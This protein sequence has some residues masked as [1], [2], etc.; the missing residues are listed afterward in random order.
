M[1]EKQEKL[2]PAQ[3]RATGSAK[4]GRRTALRI[5]AAAG[6]AA[7]MGPWIVRD[8]FSSSG[9]LNIMMWS[10]YLPRAVLQRF[11]KTTGIKVRHTPYGSND[12][13]FNKLKASKGRNFDLVSPTVSRAGQWKELALLQP[14]DMKKVDLKKIDSKILATVTAAGSWDGNAYLVPF[15][16]GT[17]GM[18]WNT[19]KWARTPADLSFGDLWLPEMKGQAM[20]RPASMM[21]GLGLYL[22][23]IGRLPSNR[24]LD[25]YKDEASMRDIWREIGKFAIKRKSWFKSYWSDAQGQISGF[26][27]NGVV[28]GQVWDGPAMR[29]KGEGFP[30]TY[31]APIEGAIGWIDGLSMPV[32]AEN[33]AQAYEF[34]KFIFTP[35]HGAAFSNATGYDT[36]GVGTEKHLSKPMREKH[37]TIYPGDAFEKIWWR[38]AEPIW[39]SAIRNEF[40]DRFAAA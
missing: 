6:A 38:P 28:L 10:D 40:A 36:C 16:W 7:A 3:I 8:A 37:K 11:E 20:A 21:A 19:E 32:G 35:S 17:E 14:W 25:A 22:D 26:T 39:Y 29:L 27:Q 31:M 12:E 15:V 5:T 23:R 13:L 9:H 30:I 1:P 33:V 24:M 34:V 18:A 2:I 4:I